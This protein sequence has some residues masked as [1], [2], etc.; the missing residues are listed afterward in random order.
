[1]EFHSLMNFSWQAF[2]ASFKLIP[3][4]SWSR[5]RSVGSVDLWFQPIW[6]HFF[7]ISSKLVD[8]LVVDGI[9]V[10]IRDMR[11]KSKLYSS[12]MSNPFQMSKCALAFWTNDRVRREKN[13]G[14]KIKCWIMLPFQKYLIRFEK[15]TCSFFKN[16]SRKY[17][18]KNLSFS[19]LL[20]KWLCYLR[21]HL[22]SRLRLLS[23]APELPK[24]N[25][26]SSYSM[27]ITQKVSSWDF[28]FVC[29]QPRW[30]WVMKSWAL[31]F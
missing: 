8:I 21:C 14:N 28:S 13:F 18:F 26:G 30:M 29:F 2:I 16:S 7:N 5:W 9:P 19:C 4:I 10:V 6:M 22:G 17:I 12:I 24:F 15:W 1:M 20:G 25:L 11:K 27:K 23:K 31:I 3:I